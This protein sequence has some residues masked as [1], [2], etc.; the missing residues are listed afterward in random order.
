MPVHP[1]R[2]VD[3]G[4]AESTAALARLRRRRAAPGSAG[5]WAGPRL[6]GARSS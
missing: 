2:R 5:Q 3:R 4:Q 1:H 6:P